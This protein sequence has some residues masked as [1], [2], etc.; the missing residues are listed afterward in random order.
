VVEERK[1]AEKR[2]EDLE[3]ELAAFVAKDIVKQGA[4]HEKELFTIHKH[5][6]DDT[7]GFLSAVS[8]NIATEWSAGPSPSRPYLIVL[9]SSPTSQTTTSTSL[10]VIF[11]SSDAKVKEVGDALKSKVGVKGG[12]KGN[13]WSGKFIGVWKMPKEGAAIAEVLE[14]L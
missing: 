12:G 9:S 5:R 3:A 7:L 1:R 6:N 4:D 14:K 10:V 11:G 13:K 2:V 8:A